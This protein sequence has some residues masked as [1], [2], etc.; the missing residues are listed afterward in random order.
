M[1][2]LPRAVPSLCFSARGAAATLRD[3]RGQ[4]EWRRPHRATL[5]NILHHRAYAGTYRY[6]YRDRY[7][8]LILDRYGKSS[9]EYLLIQPA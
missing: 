6:G 4:L 8:V 7:G 3:N 9:G 5:L 2:I 1:R